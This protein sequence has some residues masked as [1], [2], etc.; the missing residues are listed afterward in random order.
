MRGG[1]LGSIQDSNGSLIGD[2]LRLGMSS[3][4]NIMSNA[5]FLRGR[6]REYWAHKKPGLQGHHLSYL[7]CHLRGLTLII[8]MPTAG[9]GESE[10]A[11]DLLYTGSTP[12]NHENMEILGRSE[13]VST[14]IFI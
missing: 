7:A 2:G 13:G 10:F 14:W 1:N 5:I 11:D 6:F 12:E 9:V 8:G 3:I 4:R